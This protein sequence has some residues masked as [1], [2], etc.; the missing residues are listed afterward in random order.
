ME[1]RTINLGQALRSVVLLARVASPGR[2]ARE[3]ALRRRC[4]S[5]KSVIEF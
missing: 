4:G 2:G 1:G 5:A 3:E